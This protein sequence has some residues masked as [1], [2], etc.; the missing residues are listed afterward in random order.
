MRVIGYES[1]KSSHRVLVGRSRVVESLAVGPTEPAGGSCGMAH[2]ISSPHVAFEHAA[3]SRPI[4]I[5]HDPRGPME[6]LDPHGSAD[7]TN[8]RLWPT[9]LALS[10]FLCAHP[11][12][13]AGK[14]IV[15]L[16]SGSGAVGLCC[17][18]LG[19]AEVVLTDVPDALALIRQNA[20]LNPPSS[21][22]AVRVAPCTWGEETHLHELLT[23][24]PYD[25]VLCCELVYQ[26][27]A[28]VLIAL[29][30]TQRAL[31]GPKA[32]VLL[33][34]EFRNA[35]G[36]DLAYFDAATDLFG[37]STSHPLDTDAAAV[38]RM[39]GRKDSDRDDRFLYIYEMPP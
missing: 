26:Q 23:A 14:R 7:G 36:D 30:H 8:L 6:S 27:P 39:G 2:F 37:D 33:A 21:G 28:D 24:G 32:K 15:E 29:A 18:A 19:A 9:A 11:E 3:L 34:Y 35:L 31:A 22:T 5:E 13:V 38:R 20:A 16:G 17:A 4:H 10:S 25:V 1:A 12:L